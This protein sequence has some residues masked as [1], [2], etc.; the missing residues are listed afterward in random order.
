MPFPSCCCRILIAGGRGGIYTLLSSFLL[1]NWLRLELKN[2]WFSLPVNY[3]KHS[4][5]IQ[6]FFKVPLIF[7][8]YSKSP[9]S[10]KT[11]FALLLL[12]LW[13]SYSRR[14]REDLHS[15]LPIPTAELIEIGIKIFDFLCLLYIANTP[16]L[17]K[18]FSKSH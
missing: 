16:I 3:C 14:Q 12:L 11:Y 9:L 5:F 7:N 8:F 13:N 6:K 10:Y 17:F 15:S 2:I 4:Y 18:K 1:R